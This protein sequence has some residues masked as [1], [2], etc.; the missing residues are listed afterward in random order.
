MRKFVVLSSGF[1][2]LLFLTLAECTS[3]DDQ[4]VLQSKE[5]NMC[6]IHSTMPNEFTRSNVSVTFGQF[7][8]PLLT[9][10]PISF[11]F[12]RNHP[13]H[14]PKLRGVEGIEEA[15]NTQSDGDLAAFLK[16][17]SSL[18]P[19]QIADVVSYRTYG[20]ARHAET[21]RDCDKV[22][23]LMSYPPKTGGESFERTM[24][25]GDVDHTRA[26]F[27]CT[28]HQHYAS[29]MK[30]VEEKHLDPKCEVHVMTIRDPKERYISALR[31]SNSEDQKS[32]N[33]KGPWTLSGLLKTVDSYSQGVAHWPGYFN[34]NWLPTH[35]TEGKDDETECLEFKSGTANR[36]VVVGHIELMDFILPLEY[37]QEAFVLLSADMELDLHELIVYYQDHTQVDFDTSLTETEQ[38]KLDHIWQ[39]TY[40]SMYWQEAV[41]KFERQKREIREKYAPGP[42]YVPASFSCSKEIKLSNAHLTRYCTRGSDE[43]VLPSS[44]SLDS[45]S[46]L[47]MSKMF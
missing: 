14:S 34:A 7:K 2:L 27:C 20:C 39:G 24:K 35:F 11:C 32:I 23:F 18:A 33:P 3:V 30:Q 21:W 45:S 29:L 22:Q 10:D 42:E 38:A 6:A 36:E 16:S 37:F 47:E 40:S 12:R 26:S 44:G 9:L 41:R 5:K 4:H 25:F 28:N 15:I 13:G 8:I 31:A 1:V 46:F 19:N 43:W 17:K